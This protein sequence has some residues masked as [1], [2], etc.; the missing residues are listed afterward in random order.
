[1]H[2]VCCGRA[3]CTS[4]SGPGR[5]A[6]SVPSPPRDGP[7]TAS[8]R[9]IPS[10][11]GRPSGNLHAPQLVCSRSCRDDLSERPVLRRP[12]QPP[13]GEGNDRARSRTGA[14]CEAQA[15]LEGRNDTSKGLRRDRSSIRSVIRIP[16][17][18]TARRALRTPQPCP[19]RGKSSAER[20]PLTTPTSTP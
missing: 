10:P 18:P 20:R 2:A 6:A 4:R 1:M 12:C 9:H 8:G 19:Y 3:D 7:A 14:C 15:H 16:H 13:C 5:Q 17:G 11:M